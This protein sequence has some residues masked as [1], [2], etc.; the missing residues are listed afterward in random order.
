MK[1]HT[2]K[3]IIPLSLIL[4]IAAC[5]SP[6]SGNNE[7]AEEKIDEAAQALGEKKYT[8]YK[9]PP[10]PEYADASLKLTAPQ[11]L[12]DTGDT[13]FEFEVANYELGA[14]TADAAERGIAN[15]GK[16]QH[17]HFILNNDPYSAHYE[18]TF[19]KNLPV[20]N[21]VVL[22]FLS[23]S[24]HE[25]VKNG[26]SH[27]VQQFTVGSPENPLEF[28]PNGQHLFYSRPKGTYKGADT[29]KLMLDFFLVNTS[30]SPDGNKVK[31]TINGET[32]LITEWAPY[33]IEGLDKGV[34]TI[35]LELVDA[36]GNF[37]PGPFNRVT[38]KVTLE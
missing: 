24:Y 23:R 19:T 20:G 11:T 13:Q 17:I 22:A 12:L 37:I 29:E 35:E 9:A 34:V 15:S 18:P 4:C 14:Q 26:K 30:I 33:Y 38:R 3:L 31:A 2:F 16:G 21:H 7:N 6:K 32:H 25:S 8:V 1:N 5:N 28:D 10:S 36:D 27:V